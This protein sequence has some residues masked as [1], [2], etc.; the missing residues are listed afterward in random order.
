MIRLALMYGRRIE[1]DW[2]YLKLLSAVPIFLFCTVSLS[3]FV[4]SSAF[5]DRLIG[6][7]SSMLFLFLARLVYLHAK[8]NRL[9]AFSEDRA[10]IAVVFM[11]WYLAALFI[12]ALAA[13]FA[14][15]SITN[16]ELSRTA[17]PGSY[18]GSIIFVQVMALTAVADFLDVK[19]EGKKP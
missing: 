18:L 5:W 16:T 3:F 19:R 8:D 1:T 13:P 12:S 6:I 17:S 15:D 9:P 2:Y 7:F 11:G 14:A 4:S 10:P